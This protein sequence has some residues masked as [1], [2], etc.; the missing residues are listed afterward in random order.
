MQ[1]SIDL[2]IIQQLEAFRSPSSKAKRGLGLP[3]IEQIRA[4]GATIDKVTAQLKT[5]FAGLDTQIDHIMGLVR[6]WFVLPQAQRRPTVISF[7]G[8]TGVG[9]SSFVLRLVELLEMRSNY[10]YVDLGKAVEKSSIRMDTAAPFPNS[11]MRMS[12]SAGIMFF[13]EMHSVRTVD[14]MGN[15]IDRPQ[16]CDFWTLI[17]SG[18]VNQSFESYVW[19]INRN[20]A[21]MRSVA[22]QLPGEMDY[23]GDE[24]S[25]D[26]IINLL[27]LKVS[28]RDL[29]EVAVR[30]PLTYLQ[31]STSLLEQGVKD[32]Q[33][34]DYTQCL[35]FTAG[36][37]DEV[38]RDSFALNP[39]DM[40]AEDLY[41]KTSKIGPDR[42]KQALLRRFRPEQ[43][44]RLGS[45]QI[46]FPSL[47]KAAF[48]SLIR[49]RLGEISK[50]LDK[51]FQLKL[52]FDESVTQLILHEGVVPAQGAR[53]VLSTIT[54]HL[55]IRTASWVIAASTAAAKELR[56]VFDPSTKTLECR[57]GGKSLHAAELRLREDRLPE[58]D[59]SPAMNEAIC[60]H[61]AGHAVAG[62][63]LQGRLPI[64]VLT[65]SMAWHRGGPRVE[66]RPVE[67]MTRETA[68]N[69][70]SIMLAGYA[71]E[72]L[73]FGTRGISLGASSDLQK[74]TDLAGSMVMQC[75]LGTHLSA[76]FE[77]QGVPFNTTTHKKTDDTAVEK[78]LEAAMVRVRK[79]F[80]EQRA[81]LDAVVDQLMHQERV[82]GKQLA[83][84][85]LEHYRGDE[86]EIRAITSRKDPREEESERRHR[87]P[88]RKSSLKRAA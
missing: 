43:V 53:P 10:G 16:L 38:Y 85:V 79:V 14:E 2:T 6:P 71:A 84:V 8:M 40:N 74:A 4:R 29:R 54:E 65:G 56:V 3:D 88:K 46:V 30:D 24:A 11:I 68:E 18:L 1:N 37:L 34:L 87:S 21:E 15:D 70:L 47:S 32:L 76:S 17:D 80:S 57:A 25:L 51:S 75:G 77:S 5:E 55:E 33:P 31:W 36:N 48:Q 67:F 42:V 7:W 86:E 50:W 58:I 72:E 63:V 44:A 61:E 20:L 22:K 60:V 52:T 59:I 35:I 28:A 83:E 12:G 66:F 23:F 27:E 13:D 81:L 19:A 39:D 73:Y 45:L 26:M 49:L 62:I 9:K 82:T 78:L 69:L 41:E 64:K